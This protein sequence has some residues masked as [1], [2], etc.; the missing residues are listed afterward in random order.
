MQ[1]KEEALAGE[2]EEGQLHQGLPNPLEPQ[3]HHLERRVS[4]E[5]EEVE[6]PRGA[7]YWLEA[8]E[9]EP[10]RGASYWLE[11]EEVEPPRG[12]SCRLEA[13]E[14]EH[15]PVGGSVVEEVARPREQ[16]QAFEHSPAQRR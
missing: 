11:A 6:P 10:P 4:G 14:E 7:S 3:Q 2:P 13:E 8:E 12:A 9:V 16:G 15:L 5:A 1:E